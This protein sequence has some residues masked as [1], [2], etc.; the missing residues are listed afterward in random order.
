MVKNFKI[1]CFK[2]NNKKTQ[3]AW[4]GTLDINEIFKKN[5]AHCVIHRMNTEE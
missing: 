3:K 2:N 4:H 1:I 5:T